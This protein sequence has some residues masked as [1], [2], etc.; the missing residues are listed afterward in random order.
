MLLRVQS[1][2]SPFL[3]CKTS[4][5]CQCGWLLFWHST[6]GRSTGACCAV[7]TA[8]DEALID[9]KNAQGFEILL[10]SKSVAGF[11]SHRGPKVCQSLPA[12]IMQECDFCGST[13]VA[14]ALFWCARDPLYS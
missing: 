10:A 3:A 5:V 11:T 4:P 12:M 8:Q 13:I 6:N 9:H 7:Q 14:D 1:T 2:A